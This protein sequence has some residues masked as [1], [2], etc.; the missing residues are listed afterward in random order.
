M[1]IYIGQMLSLQ[2]FTDK[3][4]ALE[5]ILVKGISFRYMCIHTTIIGVLCTDENDIS[6]LIFALYRD[7]S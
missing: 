1:Y 7:G 5:T 4:M 3:L 2:Q 6:E